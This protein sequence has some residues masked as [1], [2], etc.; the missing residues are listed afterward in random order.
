LT[1]KKPNLAVDEMRADLAQW[2]AYM[3]PVLDAGIPVY[4]VRGNH[5]QYAVTDP[6]GQ[7]SG[8]ADAL[9]IWDAL[10]SLPDGSVNPITV[11][12]DT[13]YS[14]DSTRRT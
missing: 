2:K 4:Y 12:A 3:Q 11:D 10:I 8:Y 14:G 5:D 9:A 13:A 6:T 1:I 7:G